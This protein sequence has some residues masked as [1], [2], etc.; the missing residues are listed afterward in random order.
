MRHCW[1]CH[2][3][4]DVQEIRM[5][6]KAEQW[7]VEHGG[8]LEAARRQQGEEGI[9]RRCASLPQEELLRRAKAQTIRNMLAERGR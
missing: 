5:T 9:C 1:L 8:N 2:S 7:L 6:P 3:T 4:K